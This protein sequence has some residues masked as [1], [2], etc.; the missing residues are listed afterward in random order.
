M[1][2]LIWLLLHELQKTGCLEPMV[3][4]LLQDLSSQENKPRNIW[5]AKQAILQQFLPA[6]SSDLT[7]SPWRPLIIELFG[8]AADGRKAARA[9]NPDENEHFEA[10]LHVWSIPFFI[11]YAKAFTNFLNPDFNSVTIPSTWEY[12]S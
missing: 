1:W 7:L 8:I 11:R 9:F 3:V 10:N 5:A 6:E 2:V 12:A 4:G